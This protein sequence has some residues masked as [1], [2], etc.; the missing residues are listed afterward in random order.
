MI[1]IEVRVLM[2]LQLRACLLSNEIRDNKQHINGSVQN[3]SKSFRIVIFDVLYTM[4]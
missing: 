4:I 2:V 1:L 3:N